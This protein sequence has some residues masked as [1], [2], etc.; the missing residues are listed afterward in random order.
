[1]ECPAVALLARRNNDH[2]DDTNASGA[3][4][5]QCAFA[6]CRRRYSYRSFCYGFR[7]D[8]LIRCRQLSVAEHGSPADV[9]RGSRDRY[10]AHGQHHHLD[11]HPSDDRRFRVFGRW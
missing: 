8:S 9:E 3:R 6:H 7:H 1:M 10:Y 2:N 4:T 11:G 5:N